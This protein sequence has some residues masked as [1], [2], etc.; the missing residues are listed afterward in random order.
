MAEATWTLW[1]SEDFAGAFVDLVVP[2]AGPTEWEMFWQALRI[3]PFRLQ[4]FRDGE[5]VALPESTS[6]F[7][8]EQEIASVHVS[9][10]ADN[11]MMNC[12][13][14]DVEWDLDF[15]PREIVNETSFETMLKM[16]RFVAAAVSVPVFAVY[17]GTTDTQFAFIRISPE[18]EVV[19]LPPPVQIT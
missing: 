2:E 16:M 6:W 12:F 7:I 13:F 17:E 14:R 10:V 15:D 9:V 11:V 1:Q 3:G 18:G 5:P 8:S 19:F 4:T